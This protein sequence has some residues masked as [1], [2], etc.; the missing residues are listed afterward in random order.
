M[1]LNLSAGTAHRQR[2]SGGHPPRRAARM[3]RQS[4]SG[5]AIKIMRY[6]NN[7]ERDRTQNRISLLLIALCATLS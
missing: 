7:L 4:V 1:D 5:L 2:R 6:L 3:I